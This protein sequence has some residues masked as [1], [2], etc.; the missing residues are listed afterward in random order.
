MSLAS[1]RAAPSRR[2]VIDQRPLTVKLLWGLGGD[3]SPWGRDPQVLRGFVQLTGWQTNAF[4]GF[5][6]PIRPKLGR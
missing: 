1:Y 4:S 2:R 5:P 3:F 6:S